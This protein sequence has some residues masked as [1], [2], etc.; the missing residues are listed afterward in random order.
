MSSYNQVRTRTAIV[1]LITAQQATIMAGLDAVRVTKKSEIVGAFFE[2]Q[3]RTFLADKLPVGL[4][5]TPGFIVGRDGKPSS[6]FDGLIVDTRYP[7]LGGIDVHKYVMIDSVVAAIE[8]SSILTTRK[9]REIMAKHN[10]IRT[11]EKDRDAGRH[12]T[13]FYGILGNAEFGKVA[14]R[15]AM[16]EHSFRGDIIM[17]SDRRADEIGRHCWMEPKA[18][19]PTKF[20]P[21]ARRTETPLSD[22]T[23]MI[24]QDTLFA[25]EEPMLDTGHIAE[26]MNSFI[27]WGTVPPKATE[28]TTR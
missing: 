1:D 8:L 12:A 3:I 9:L 26:R 15:K 10:E 4:A 14:I 5:V 19:E 28:E 6:H 7:Y 22:L 25:L 23:A 27:M 24:V 18:K 20:V 2:T 17:L 21:T 11:L 13:C 16:I